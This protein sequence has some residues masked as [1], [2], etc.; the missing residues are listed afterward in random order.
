MVQRRFEDLFNPQTVAVVGATESEGSIGRAIME[1]LLKSFNGD[2]V[3]VNPNYD[4]VFDRK[5]Y[6][7]LADVPDEIDLVVIVVP[8]KIV[9]DILRQAGELGIT[10]VVVIT[11]GFGET[12]SE[13]AARQRELQSVASEYGINVVG[14]NSLGVMNT[15]AGLNATF[16]PEIALSGS[17]S[18]MSQSGAFITAVVDWA[19]DEGIG[20]KD[21]VSLGN[22][23]VLNET[24]FIREWNQ[25]PETDVILAYLESIKDGKRFIETAREVTS[26]TPVV[27]VKSGRT[28]AG[29]KAASSHT[30]ALAG[31]E[32]AYEAG[33]EQA[34]VIRA[35]NIQEM[36]D[37]ARVLESQPTPESNKV[38][39]VTNAGGPGVMTT[40]AVGDS[41]LSLASFSHET[42]SALSEE[43]PEEA[44][45]YNPID[46]IGDADIERLRKAI[47]IALGDENVGAGIVI[48]CP[49]ALLDYSE[50]AEVV[51]ELQEKHSKP[52]VTSLM[53]GEDTEPAEQ[54]LRENGVP[55]YFDPARG[56]K[57]LEAL[58]KYRRI[59]QRV[60]EPPV[61]F[62]VD[63]EKA[64]DVLQKARERDDNRLGVEAMGLLDAYGIPIPEGE[65]VSSPEDAKEAARA[66][67]G[68]VVMKI[69]SPDILHKT[70]IGGVKVG[71][72]E[73]DVYDAYEDLITRAR[74]Y[75]PDATILGVQVQEMVDIDSGV[76]TIVGMNRDPQFG[77]LLMFGLGG[78]FVEVLKDTSFRVAPVNE[79]EA[80]NMI[81]EIKSS[82]L[83][84][85][86]RGRDPVAVEGVVESIQRLSQLVTDFPEILELDINPLVAMSDGVVAIDIR[87]TIDIDTEK[88]E[89]EE[90]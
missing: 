46:A 41:E 36:F 53:G 50:L 10:N 78:I 12:G 15:R 47:D 34:G 64:R 13:G 14:P 86:A 89:R 63:R 6:P 75:Q 9:V 17:I 52:I 27:I 74:N 3:P 40:D 37:F 22:K 69:V 82:S 88:E 85:G 45:I 62:D 61:E 56:I 23:A 54:I 21:I 26:E 38:A 58:E 57:S 80:R 18:F 7:E 59:T 76:E 90:K 44:N 83:L 11:A 66:I 72:S 48:S 24:D 35:M 42:L 79:K 51:V 20:F 87:L 39:I 32:T 70:D 81:N 65:I 33:L 2:I 8:P 77:P 19:N 31:S 16:G 1:N 28:E 4:E 49:T 73:E 71:V 67:E 60:Y 25:D 55:N 43:M 30:G 68:D 29:A 84:R 5:S